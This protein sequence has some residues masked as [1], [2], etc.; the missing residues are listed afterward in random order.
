MLPRIQYAQAPDRISIAFWAVGDGVPLLVMYPP[1][2][3]NIQYEWEMPETAR[4]YESAKTWATV[5]R[6]DHR[7]N[8][9]SERGAADVSIEGFANDLEGVLNRL[10]L[11]R[12][13]LFAAAGC[14]KV[15]I[16]FA[17]HNPGRIAS[18]V[19]FR[20]N[21]DPGDSTA[22]PE[23]TSLRPILDRDWQLFTNLLA[24]AIN[25]LVDGEQTARIAR[26]LRESSTPEEFLAANDA[27]ARADV[28]PLLRLSAAPCWCSTGWTRPSS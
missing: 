14:G 4:V 5:I 1:G 18:L 21:P 26:Y 15:A 13:H 7:N 2:F 8:G 24:T 16:H 3:S 17:A 11:G 12:V 28:R 19:L 20:T 27:L 25:G 10:D 22:A 6:F 9:L 23:W